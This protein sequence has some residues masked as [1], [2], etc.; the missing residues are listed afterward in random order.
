MLLGILQAILTFASPWLILELTAFIKD[1]DQHPDL[2]WET[3]KPGVIYSAGL[4]GTQLLSYCLS[5]HMTYH[6]V[7]TGRRSSNAVI[8]FIYQKYSK[9]SSATNKD[10]SSGQIV[11]FV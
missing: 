9:V 11:N 7:L 2:D 10:F 6:N 5:E 4:I 8:A 3:V 1:G